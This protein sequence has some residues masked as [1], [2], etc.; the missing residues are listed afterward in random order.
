MLPR[1][2]SGK[3]IHL[4]MQE[5][6]VQSLGW[7]PLEE[8]MTTHSSVHAWEIPWTEEPGGYSAW[9]CKRVAHDLVNKQQQ[10]PLYAKM[11][12]FSGMASNRFVFIG[13]HSLSHNLD[14][15]V[16]RKKAYIVGRH[17]HYSKL[18][19]Y[20]HRA[21]LGSQNKSSEWD[22]PFCLSLSHTHTHSIKWDPWSHISK[23]ISFSVFFPNI[24]IWFL[25]RVG[26]LIRKIAIVIQILW[27]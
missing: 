7:D 14:W 15:T 4:P 27:C 22:I 2:L 18:L 5:M 25:I 6:W 20:D 19:P 10:P 8:E 23:N 13:A 17:A 11:S 26:F 24:Y 12:I 1:W 21:I 3:E 9:D 16:K